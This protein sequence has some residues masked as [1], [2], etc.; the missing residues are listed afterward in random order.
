MVNGYIARL[1]MPNRKIAVC[2]CETDPFKVFRI[3][4]PFIWGYYDG[5]EYKTFYDTE[6]F[7]AFLCEQNVICYAHNGGKFDWHFLLPYASPYDE[8]SLINGRIAKIRFG[9]CEA[10]DSYNI[11]PVPLAAYK[12]DEIDYSIME[13]ANRNWGNNPAKIKK[14]LRSDCVYLYE[15]V[16][17]FISEFG[18]NLTQAGAAM[19]QWSKICKENNGPAIP[20][21]T[22]EFYEAF[23]PYYYGGR[24]QCFRS[25]IVET[26]FSV[27]DMRS[28]YP[29]AMLHRHPYSDNYSHVEGYAKGADFYKVRCISHG[30]LPFRGAGEGL[31]FPD[32]DELRDYTITGWEYQAALDTDALSNVEIRESIT[33]VAHIDFADYIHHF[34]NKRLEC[35]AKGD[36]SGS[37]LNKLLMNSLYGKFAANPDNYHNYMIVPMENIAGLGKC[38]FCQLFDAGKTLKQIDA[39]GLHQCTCT[40]WDFAGEFG[41]W[42]LAQSDLAEERKRYYNVATGASITG[43]VRANL[44][45][46]IHSSKGVI[47]C[48]TD[49]IAVQA[50]GAAVQ[51]GEALG[52]WGHEGDF[53]KAGIAGKKM[54]IF[55]GV[56]EPGKTRAYKT[57]S[58]GVRLTHAQLW[59]AARGE[60]VEHTN[61]APTFSPTRSISKILEMPLNQRAKRQITEKHFTTRR[62]RKT[63]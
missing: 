49:S 31:S 56:P 41:P 46:A 30:A 4:K 8:V 34:Y 26:R 62:V 12:K 44:W 16:S 6:D 36:E 14:Y 61:I 20:K 21:T 22:G 45:R 15:L 13:E 35:K 32:D 60:I 50:K 7:V 28:A 18:M 51:L 17:R 11:I 9:N 3:P 38:G 19:K 29:N 54:Y 37:L 1:K 10:R 23:A 48:D 63:A 53:D 59:K 58:K 47:Y 43:F 5:E 2:D 52:Q 33:F 25:G 24:V 40:G 39:K 55:R 57:A 27:F 42:G